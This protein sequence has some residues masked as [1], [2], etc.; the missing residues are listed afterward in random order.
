MPLR[1]MHIHLQLTRLDTVKDNGQRTRIFGYA[2][3]H[4]LLVCLIVALTMCCTAPF[5]LDCLPWWTIATCRHLLNRF[6]KGIFTPCCGL[7]RVNQS[8]NGGLEVL[9]PEC[10]QNEGF[11][12]PWLMQLTSAMMSA[13]PELHSSSQRRGVMPLVLFWKRSGNISAKSLKLEH[14]KRDTMFTP[15]GHVERHNTKQ[16]PQLSIT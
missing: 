1:E 11:Q 6:V 16:G 2:I 8:L 9:V 5:T 15:C 7:Q 10:A 3:V 4:D 12:E 13:R 14:A